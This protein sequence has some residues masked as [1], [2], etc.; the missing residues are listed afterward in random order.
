MTPP[1]Q[2]PVGDAIDLELGEAYYGAQKASEDKL[3]DE[4]IDL[5][6]EF[7]RRRFR[8]GRRPALRDAHT[9]DNG[10]VHAIFRV[11]PDLKNELRIGVFSQL[12]REYKAWIRFSNGNSERQNSRFPDARGMAIKLMGVGGQKLLD[13]LGEDEEKN[14]QDFILISSPAFFV[15]D[16][17]RYNKTLRQYLSGGTI[18]QYLS[19]LK[20]RG[21]EIWIAFKVNLT[22]LTNPLFHQYWSMTPYRLGVPPGP[23]YAVKYTAKPCSPNPANFLCRL[24]TFLAPGFSLKTEMNKTLA[25]R[26]VCF[27]FFIQRYVDE[28]RTP[29]EDTTVVWNETVSRPEHVAKIIIPSQDLMCAERASF[30]ENLSFS[31]WHGLPEHKPLG[32]IN[33]V[34]KR[35]YLEISKYR[36]ALNGIP[37]QEPTGAEPV[38]S[39]TDSTAALRD[40][41]GTTKTP[42]DWRRTAMRV[43]YGILGT[44]GLLILVLVCAGA[45]L[46]ATISQ[47]PR[48]GSVRDEAA[49]AGLDENHFAVAHL[50]DDEYFDEMDNWQLATPE[51]KYGRTMWM[52][53]TGGNDRFWDAITNYTFGTFDLLKT[54][55]SHP[56]LKFGGDKRFAYLGVMNEPCFERAKGPDPK[57]FDLWLDQRNPAC[58]PDPFADD[59]KYPGVKIG[60]RRD[61]SMPSGSYYGEPT[62]IIG[63]RLFPNPA[64]DETARKNWDAERYYTDES[65][66]L[67][68]KLVRPYRVGM[69]CAFCHVGP[70]PR[71]PPRD[72]EH[73]EWK[74][75]NSTVGAQ[76][77]WL[78]RVFNWKGDEN[79]VIF[80]LLHTA[81]PGTFDTSLVSTDNIVNPRTNNAIYNFQS[82]M[83]QARRFGREK[84]SGGQL[85]NKQFDDFP[86]AKDLNNFYE[87]P[88]V[89]TPRVLKDGSDSVGVL[90]ALN[91]VHLNIGLFSEEWMLHFSPF[92]GMMRIS[93]IRIATAQRNSTYWRATEQQS[94]Y[95]VR[96]LLGAGKPDYLKDAPGGKEYL[97]DN[98]A[99][100]DRGK[101]VFA[102]RCA[103]CHSSKL[104][105]P[106]EG[107]Q[108][109]EQG[110]CAGANYLNCWK[111]YWEWTKTVDFKKK[112]LDLVNKSD[113]LEDNF[114]S[115][116]FRVPVTLLQTNACSPLATNAIANNIWDDFS[117]QSFKELPSVGE[118]TYQDPFDGATRRYQ[119][120]A[121]GRGYTRPASLVSLWSTAPYLLN[122]T[123]GPFKSD[124]S[125]AERVREFDIAI[126][127]L[128]WPEKREHDQVL[129]SKGVGWI[130]RTSEH[131]WIKVPHGFLPGF[132]GALRRPINW[133]LPGAMDDKGDLKIG[134][135]P[136]GTPIALIG[137]LSPLPES[138]DLWS[139][140]KRGW[141]LLRVGWRL[142]KYA[143]AL[144]PNA[145]NEEAQRL[146]EPVARAFYELSNC[147]DFVVNRGHY[148]GTD[149]LE[150]EP[151][152]SDA[153]KEALIEF[154]KRL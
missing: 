138:T 154:L 21:K 146:F 123:V 82:R 50:R 32:A 141:A 66:Y 57:R 30:C 89:Y 42:T 125:V 129:G 132:V 25:E 104:P 4:T 40:S 80:Q 84:L 117:S 37:R 93:P 35:V 71:N 65:Y 143:S 73:P 114:L 136:K 109:P 121:G 46:V 145:S 31:P 2:P 107:M 26:D 108:Y 29:I 10:C 48:T 142:H 101:T 59:K 68:S 116:E 11:D 60:A 113:F 33:R 99:V 9:K 95:M 18:A 148:F 36:H 5:S 16:L 112:M 1:I 147:P 64:F 6:K 83:K 17:I 3:T 22:L 131:S 96:F 70:N 56:S 52:V 94:I 100:L 49:R 110:A 55:S 27:D 63:L 122:N 88:Y 90:G 15:D 102:E 13:N 152:L 98:A 135:I 45:V 12:G 7:I 74:G 54:I 86:Q 62:G 134:P 150:E 133:F 130:D 8:Q 61:G 67:N 120:P 127:M 79:D 118:I 19:V 140:L 97:G 139:E 106:P 92:L 149:R 77:L 20:L 34:R 76:Y 75:L 144:P 14:T 137:S 78:D 124:P 153:D 47:G 39:R 38:C 85:D 23:R 115:T 151:G 43:L 128:L 87:K 58:P 111:P 91:R 126:H 51:E 103:R 44:V 105:L 69:A 72:P 81:R 53:W 24:K 41:S 119:M 28:E